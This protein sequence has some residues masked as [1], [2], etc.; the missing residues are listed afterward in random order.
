ML[1]RNIAIGLI[2]G[3]TLGGLA[4][5]ATTGWVIN[6]WR[7]S[8]KVE[9]LNGKVDA[10]DQAIASLGDI[11]A[12]C[13]SSVA[14]VKAAVKEIADDAAKRAAA[15]A[16]AM[17]RAEKGAGAYLANARAALARPAP[18]PGGECEA[19]VRE[20]IDYAGRRKAGQ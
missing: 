8:G 11:N 1:T 3:G 14:D 20:A 9:R 17:Q 19:M 6:G 15:A 10:R 5:G 4:I 12:R 18:A 16:T 2:I 7:L 13:T